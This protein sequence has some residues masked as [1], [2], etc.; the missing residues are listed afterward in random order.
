MG[1]VA[2]DL[3]AGPWRH[4][5]ER[6][7]PTNGRQAGKDRSWGRTSPTCPGRPMPH[8]NGWGIRGLTAVSARGEDDTSHACAERACNPVKTYKITLPYSGSDDCDPSMNDPPRATGWC[9]IWLLLDLVDGRA[10]A[11]ST[12]RLLTD[13][14]CCVGATQS[15]LSVLEDEPCARSPV[16]Q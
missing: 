3:S 6:S 8:A 10:S 5:P 16:A 12:S 9:Q 14:D 4:H 15:A 13:D 7:A 1:D 11:Y 2:F